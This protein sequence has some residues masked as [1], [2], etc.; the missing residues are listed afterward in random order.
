MLFQRRTLKHE[1][2]K[3]GLLLPPPRSLPLQLLQSSSLGSCRQLN[4][5]KGRCVSSWTR[6]TLTPLLRNQFGTEVVSHRYVDNWYIIIHQNVKQGFIKLV[7]C[8][9]CSQ[10]YM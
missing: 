4:R 3:I 6:S 5:L 2:S 1:C 8:F 7:N 9:L 10:I